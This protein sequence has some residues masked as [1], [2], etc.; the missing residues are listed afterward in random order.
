M[1]RNLL[2]IIGIVA[3]IVTFLL[4]PSGPAAAQD[5]IV[6][7]AA[8]GTLKPAVLDTGTVKRTLPTLSGGTRVTAAEVLQAQSGSSTGAATSAAAYRANLASGGKQTAVRRAST[9]LRTMSVSRTAA[10]QTGDN[11][12]SQMGFALSTYGCSARRGQGGDANGNSSQSNGQGSN[13]RVNQDC[14]FRRQAEET[15]IYNPV[16]PTN[17]L[18]GQNDSRVGFNQTGFD[19]SLNNGK[20]W[21]DGLPPFRQK[22]NNPAREEP[23]AADPNR[24]TIQGGPGTLHTYD[25]ASDP[26]VAFDSQGR[27]FYSAV[28]F[29]IATNASLL[30]VT[31]SPLGAKGSFFYNIGTFDRKYVVAEDNS[32]LVFHDKNFIAADKYPNSPNRD[33]VYVTWTVFKFDPRCQAPSTPDGVAR[34]CESPIFGSMSTDHGVHW[35]TPEEISGTSDALCFFGNALDPN[36]KPNSCN[37]DQGSDP[38]VLPNGDLEVVFNNGNTGAG[39]TDSQQLGVHC[40]PTGSSP[41]GTAHLNC[42]SPSLVGRDASTG[43]PQCDFGRGPEECIPG[44][45][46]RTND[47]PRINKN[48]NGNG[49]NSNLYAT[50]QDY[51]NGEYDI[52]LSVSHDGGLTWKEAGTVNPDRGLDHY[53]PAV[54]IAPAGNGENGNGNGN[55]AGDNGSRDRVGDSY[56]RTERVPN[57]DTTPSGGFAPGQPGVQQGNSDYVLAGGTGEQTPYNFKVLSPVFAPPDGVQAGFNGDYSGL[58]INRGVEAHPIWSDTRNVDPYS[59]QNGVVHDEDIFTDA[60]QLPNG[61]GQKSTGHVGQG[62]GGD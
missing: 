32:P 9:R 25:A 17:L 61:T 18:A 45:Y 59:P 36:A 21:G 34:Y 35:S 39:I 47:F 8:R 19:W 40:H 50:W 20:N 52:Q 53:F 15:I 24:H 56:Y 16:D 26:A 57:E 29:D 37:F 2:S 22:L 42:I 10:K 6:K 48:V 30:F 49:L 62:S 31:Q 23:T 12:N 14:T 13:V 43:E 1:R 55:G 27:A 46:I 44:A 58:T 60:L 3:L 41:A 5:S 28:A 4:Q 7:Q 33:N 54:D 51:R 38:T 11:G